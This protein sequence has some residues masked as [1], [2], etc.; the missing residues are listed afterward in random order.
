MPTFSDRLPTVN[1]ARLIILVGLASTS[2]VA[3]R[4]A[5]AQGEARQRQ[6]P[7]AVRIEPAQAETAG[8]VR[9]I[10]TGSE[11]IVVYG[12]RLATPD[13][14]F[15][16][17][18]Q[19]H[20]LPDGTSVVPVD[21]DI[22]SDLETDLEPGGSH[23]HVDQRVSAGAS[24]FAPLYAVLADG[25]VAGSD[26]DAAAGLWELK[27]LRDACRIVRNAFDS[28]GHPLDREQMARVLSGFSAPMHAARDEE[29]GAPLLIYMDAFFPLLK[30]AEGL[31]PSL[32]F[33]SVPLA[34]VH[35]RVSRCLLRTERLTF[36]DKVAPP[37]VTR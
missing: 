23:L 26:V 8:G 9:V 28:V 18:P 21:Y 2:L 31:R 29:R 19:P 24:A 6:I 16:P 14:R 36:L 17:G 32:T 11:P 7:L 30:V 27:E 25:T 22:R 3:A 10:N 34:S 33:L 12:L 5:G 1:A 13:G 20:F 4:Q 35:Q 15:Y 37:S